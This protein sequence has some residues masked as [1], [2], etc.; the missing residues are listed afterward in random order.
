MKRVEEA[1]KILLERPE[2]LSEPILKA[3][4]SKSIDE[5]VIYEPEEKK[6]KSERPELNPSDVET[7]LAN[8]PDISHETFKEDVCPTIVRHHYLLPLCLPLVETPLESLIVNE[9]ILPLIKSE[10]N[11][12]IPIKLLEELKSENQATILSTLA[13]HSSPDWSILQDLKNLDFSDPI[14]Q[15]NL[16]FVFLKQSETKD[17][18]MAKSMLNLIKNL[19][20][21]LDCKATEIWR[22][23]IAMNNSILKKPLEKELNKNPVN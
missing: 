6:T 13:S 12:N 9:I 8:A 18:K 2:H 17:S 16:A 22:Q 3:L 10:T 21:P 20:R 14:V 11:P 15:A 5:T 7:M 19:P 23:A 4:F 1:K